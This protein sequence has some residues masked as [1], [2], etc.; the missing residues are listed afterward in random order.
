ETLSGCLDPTELNS[1]PATEC[2]TRTG[3]FSFRKS[4]TS[5]HR[6]R[7]DPPRNPS[8]A[9]S[10]LHIRAA[11]VRKRDTNRPAWAQQH[12]K[13]APCCQVLPVTESAGLFRPNP[14]LRV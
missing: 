4:I 5:A 12:R 2:P 9:N 6:R 1:S 10:K 11:S 7:V 3:L 14:A 13:C 8:Q